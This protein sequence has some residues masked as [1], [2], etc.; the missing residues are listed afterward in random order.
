MLL[1]SCRPWRAA[2]TAP[3]LGAGLVTIR[4][5]RKEVPGGI[6]HG[7]DEGRENYPYGSWSGA[8]P[9]PLRVTP[10]TAG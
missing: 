6:H 5:R 4:R 9:G 10:G 8:G 7:W 2:T 1:V 3:D